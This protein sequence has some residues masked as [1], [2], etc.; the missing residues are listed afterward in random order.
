[1][2]GT[3]ALKSYSTFASVLICVN[4]SVLKNTEKIDDRTSSAEKCC[5][6]RSKRY[7]CCTWERKGSKQRN[8]KLSVFFCLS[9]FLFVC[10][11]CFILRWRMGGDSVNLRE[12]KNFGF[13][14]G[15]KHRISL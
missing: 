8:L 4:L 7:L 9:R 11:S 2:L 3:P 1:M 10:C 5:K 13:C 12:T 6:I 14:R 15:E